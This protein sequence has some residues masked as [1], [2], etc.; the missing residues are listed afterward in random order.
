M[1]DH[2]RYSLG[3]LV[4]ATVIAGTSRHVDGLSNTVGGVVCRE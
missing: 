2:L 4:T 1:L 3:E